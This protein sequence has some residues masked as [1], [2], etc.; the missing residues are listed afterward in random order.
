[1]DSGQVQVMKVQL[2]SS[3]KSV[4]FTGLIKKRVVATGT[5]MEAINGHHYTDVLEDVSA[6]EER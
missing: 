4:K 2:F 6:V 3:E 5:L 1:M